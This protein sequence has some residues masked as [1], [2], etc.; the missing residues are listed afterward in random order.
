MNLADGHFVRVMENGEELLKLR[1]GTRIPV[2]SKAVQQPQKH[3]SKLNVM[4]RLL[5]KV[6]INE[7]HN[8]I[9]TYKSLNT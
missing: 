7:I 5:T 8:V 1:G 4:I 9:K 2:A 6:I 3:K